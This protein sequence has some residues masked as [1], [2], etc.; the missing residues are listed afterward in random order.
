MCKL[1]AF[2]HTPGVL[3]SV[4][5]LHV[6]LAS[7]IDC[8]ECGIKKGITQEIGIMY[9]EVYDEDLDAGVHSLWPEAEFARVGSDTILE[10]T[11]L[12]F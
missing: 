12:V 4:E 9:R 1:M 2:T 11:F 10:F 3:L 5:A 7:H 8:L 6:L